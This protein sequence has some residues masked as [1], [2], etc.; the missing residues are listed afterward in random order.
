MRYGALSSALLAVIISACGG[1]DG[2]P[3]PDASSA[4]DGSGAVDG[5]TA[6]DGSVPD[7][8][9][10]DGPDMTTIDAPSAVV[11]ASSAEAGTDAPASAS[12]APQA[13]AVVDAAAPADGPSD[14]PMAD[15]AVDR[16]PPP[17]YPLY[18]SG[19]RLRVR[20]Q[21]GED[22]S[23]LSD[24]LHDTMFDTSCSP[25]M[26]EDGKTRCLPDDVEGAAGYFADAECKQ[27]LVRV[28]GGE[29]C[30]R[31]F[32]HLSFPDGRTQVRRTTGKVTPAAVWRHDEK[33]GPDGRPVVTCVPHAPEPQD[34]FVA[35]GDPLAPSQFV[36]LMLTD[37]PPTP[38]YRVT[39]RYLVGA[40][41]SKLRQTLRDT[42][43][44][45]NC[46]L[47]NT[48]A[49]T[50]CFPAQGRPIGM[51]FMRYADQAC[52]TAVV[53]LPAGETPPAFVRTPIQVTSPDNCTL[54]F[55]HLQPS[56]RLH[57]GPLFALSANGCVAAMPMAGRVAHL[58][59]PDASSNLPRIYAEPIG[60]TR[61]QG[62][63]QRLDDGTLLPGGAN[64]F[65]SKHGQ[66]CVA[67]EGGDSKV[68]CFP[69]V[70]AN[71]QAY[72]DA[73]CEQPLYL[74][75]DQPVCGVVGTPKHWI[76]TDTA[77]ACASR[78]GP[79]TRVLTRGAAATALFAPG[80][81]GCAATTRPSPVYAP[82]PEIPLAEFVTVT[83]EVE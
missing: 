1:N 60:D 55:R 39:A 2:K 38:G 69:T 30:L 11:D 33:E 8:S 34:Q 68:R 31:P 80:P 9:V 45:S 76:L 27:A 20:Y 51:P 78:E 50:R 65:D 3:T 12:D 49:G 44:D 21:K 7:G 24:G 81:T 56:G 14:S 66:S 83:H 17:T 25:R 53:E 4:Q 43:L 73:A 29:P 6:V 41:G 15:A 18:V 32:M 74:F 28:G 82:G 22:G 70:Y 67:R 79:V 72:A 57:D 63:R 35:T 52:T 54:V 37:E 77:P 71:N 46:M 47:L 64:S 5:A 61:I 10:G 16:G 40:D 26:A 58:Y 42:L 13:D 59:G 62:V 23:R 75:P 36:E 48:T 19:T